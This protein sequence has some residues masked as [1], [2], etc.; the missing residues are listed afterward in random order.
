MGEH[1]TKNTESVTLYCKQCQQF[2]QHRVDGGRRGPCMN[3]HPASK[4]QIIAAAKRRR[5]EEKR[6]LAKISP[7]LFEK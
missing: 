2:T 5:M 6:A 3:A 7:T 4:A 1:Y